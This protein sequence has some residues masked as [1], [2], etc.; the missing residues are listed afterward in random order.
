M[1]AKLTETPL[2][3][4]MLVVVCVCLQRAVAYYCADIRVYCILLQGVLA[5]RL[6]ASEESKQK[7]LEPEKKPVRLTLTS[8]SVLQIFTSDIQ[9]FRGV[10][11]KRV[12][13]IFWWQTPVI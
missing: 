1:K 5:L 9:R 7:R 13:N 8:T 11:I 3:T 6:E 10:R 2:T 12:E 4:F